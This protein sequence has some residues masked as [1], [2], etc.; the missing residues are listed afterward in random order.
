MFENRVVTKMTVPKK[1]Q[2]IEGQKGFQNLPNIAKM[3]KLRKMRWAG[4]IA[5]SRK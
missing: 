4:H 1:D 2:I 5:C 3:A